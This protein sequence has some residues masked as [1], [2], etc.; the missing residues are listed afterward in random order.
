M[1]W[2]KNVAKQIKQAIKKEY[3]RREKTGRTVTRD[4]TVNKDKIEK[5]CTMVTPL[6]DDVVQRMYYK[7]PYKQMKEMMP[8]IGFDIPFAK[9]Q[10]EIAVKALIKTCKKY[11]LFG[12]LNYSYFDKDGSPLPTEKEFRKTFQK[13]FQKEIRKEYQKEDLYE[14]D[15]R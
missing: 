2:K 14:Y 11:N 3:K 9:T 8:D 12:Y 13:C 5:E 7:I 4:L 6:N 15:E 1:S 10:Q